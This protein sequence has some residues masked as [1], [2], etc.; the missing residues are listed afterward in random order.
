[1]CG[2]AFLRRDNRNRYCS[3]KCFADSRQVYYFIRDYGLTLDAYRGLLEAQHGVCAICGQVDTTAKQILSVDHCH[4]TGKVRGLLCHH[5][6]VGLGH[7]RNDPA[8]LS[9]AAEYLGT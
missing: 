2:G 5:C 7:F 6:N 9:R 4:D 8:L 3:R 1:M